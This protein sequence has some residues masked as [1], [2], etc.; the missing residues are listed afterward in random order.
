MEFKENLEKEVLSRITY[1]SNLNK[2]DY[3]IVYVDRISGLKE[4][5]FVDIEIDGDFF[6]TFDDEG[7]L[8]QIP[9][10]RIRQIKKAGAIVWDKRK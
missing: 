5:R 10:H 2:L 6:N 3:S 1:D 7:E 8:H 9:M 4:I